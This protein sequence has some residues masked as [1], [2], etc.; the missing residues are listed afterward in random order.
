MNIQ[1]LINHLPFEDKPANAELFTNFDSNIPVWNAVVD[2]KHLKQD[3][4]SMFK[5]EKENE[6]DCVSKVGIEENNEISKTGMLKM[7]KKINK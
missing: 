1:N 3:I 6:E 7:C 4:C 5:N 2:Q